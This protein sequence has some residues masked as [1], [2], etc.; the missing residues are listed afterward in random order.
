MI[1]LFYLNE[2]TRQFV[3]KY[4]EYIKTIAG[5]CFIF[6]TIILISPEIAAKSIYPFLFFAIGNMFW[7][8]DAYYHRQIPWVFTALFF[9]VYDLILVYSRAVG[10]DAFLWLRPTIEQ[11]NEIFV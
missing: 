1:D 10:E 5:I 7:V 3:L 4:T 2:I 6:S 8:I 11:L 9:V